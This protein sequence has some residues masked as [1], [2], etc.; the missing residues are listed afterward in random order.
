[1]PAEFKNAMGEVCLYFPKWEGWNVF[2]VIAA[3]GINKKTPIRHPIN[4]KLQAHD[5]H[6]VGGWIELS[7]R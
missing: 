4:R 6:D 1:M 7:F 5:A 2:S 3:A